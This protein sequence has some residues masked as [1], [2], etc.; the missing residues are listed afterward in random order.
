MD[1]TALSYWFPIIEAAGLPVPKTIILKM[2]EEAQKEIWAMFDGIAPDGVAN[3]FFAE[4]DE[5]AKQFGYPCFL[6]TDMTSGKHFWEDTC[7]LMSI[8]DI[9][10]HVF[11]I[12]EFSEMAD[13]FG[14]DW[15]TWVV[16]ELLPT[17]PLGVCSKYGNMPICREFRYFVEDGEVK[18]H[19]P[20]WPLWTLEQ[21]KPNQEIDYESFCRVENEAELAGIASRAGKAV[22]GSWSVDLLETKR[23]WYLTDMA[24]A[25]KSY[26]WPECPFFGGGEA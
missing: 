23:G 12:A 11:R 1:K 25:S 10:N 24:E 19:H 8:D 6:R 7:L 4:I 17:M 14:L 9:P 18:C 20:Y 16:R 5:A 3:P 13:V 21:G 22:G 26:H 15:T 2:P